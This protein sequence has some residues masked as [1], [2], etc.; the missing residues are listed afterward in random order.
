MTSLFLS[1]KIATLSTA[2]SVVAG[3]MASLALV[4]VPFAGKSVVY[5]IVLAAIILPSIIIALALFFLFAQLHMIGSRVAI[6]LGHAVVSLPPV[7]VVVSAT[8]Q[9]FDQRLEQAAIIL[10]AH[11]LK[12]FWRVTLPI[13]SPGVIS[14][15]LFAFLISFDELLISLFLASPRS[16]TLPVRIFENTIY[17]IDP[18]ITAV[19]SFLIGA[20]LFVLLVVDLLRRFHAR[21]FTD[22]KKTQR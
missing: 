7:V 1:L 2:V 20:A 22:G 18:T 14:A 5:A 12:A 19:S 8:L 9:S 11:P 10:G 17:Q 4:R 21:T 16:I 15:A 3:V 13:I 6:A